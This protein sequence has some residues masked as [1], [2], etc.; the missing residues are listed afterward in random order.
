MRELLGLLYVVRFVI[1]SAAIGVLFI[2]LNVFTNYS[3]NCVF[4]IGCCST[5]FFIALFDY[6]CGLF[7]PGVPVFVLV[8]FP[9]LLAIIFVMVPVHR[10]MICG[11]MSDC[12]KGFMAE[13]K[14]EKHL[15]IPLVKRIYQYFV[16]LTAC[17]LLVVLFVYFILIS[18]RDLYESDRS[19][20]ELQAR[21][22]AETRES[23]SIDNYKD[24]KYGT[25]F[26]DD[27]GPLW[28]VYIADAR[29]V[30]FGQDDY[31]NPLTID[32][33]YMILLICCLSM[34]VI[35]TRILTNNIWSGLLAL[36]IVGMYRYAFTF[37]IEGS[38]DSFRMIGILLLSLY[39]LEVCLRLEKQ[40]KTPKRIFKRK[41]CIV[42]ILFCYFCM[43]GHEGNVYI[44][45]G[46]FVVFGFISLGR[47]IRMQ[48]LINIAICVFIGT[49]LGALKT[50]YIYMETGNLSSD[51]TL[52]FEGTMAAEKY[53]QLVQRTW[54]WGSVLDTYKASDFLIIFLGVLGIGYC[55]YIFYHKRKNK[56]QT[57]EIYALLIIGM[58]MPLFGVMNFL[59]Y[60]V[61]LSFIY[62]LRYRLYFL[63]LFSI[64]G[65]GVLNLLME[66]NLVVCGS[67]I[68]V[69]LLSFKSTLES[70]NTWDVATVNSITASYKEYAR[71]I[72]NYAEEGS[73]YVMSQ[74]FA[75][76]FYDN[77]PKLLYAPCARQ[78]VIAR[79]NREVEDA[80]K[81]QNIK[82]IAFEPTD[83]V[84]Y[85]FEQL[86]FYN[87]LQYNENVEQIIL[88]AEGGDTLPIFVIENLNV[89]ENVE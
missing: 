42:T 83:G 73:V 30:S 21:Y 87:Y 33:A 10:E 65:A 8:I 77:N 11:V 61:A 53:K 12:K 3:R 67:A 41:D 71:E 46:L 22:F 6:M 74:K 31:F 38:R 56:I 72:D 16:L 66:K 39:V 68:L 57:I 45:L 24:E 9:L 18:N 23:V 26:M 60:D 5:P 52:V 78:L 64:I 36:L 7:I 35:T 84:T 14:G 17:S 2:K 20:Y 70:Y 50:I 15:E 88:N 76:Y 19:H 32:I 48:E 47:N 69:A 34:I 80:I 86:P 58:L 44:M 63:I 59:G 85:D 37:S 29:M 25:V 28:S 82:V 27:H 51:T 4:G 62:Q 54:S 55:L 49:L 75:Y 43:Q 79:T 13:F 1:C 89:Q 40:H 81:E